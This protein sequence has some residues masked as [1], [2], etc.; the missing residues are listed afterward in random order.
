MPRVMSPAKTEAELQKIREH[1]DE[2]NASIGRAIAADFKWDQATAE[3]VQNFPQE[4]KE[5]LRD[6]SE[7]AQAI[8]KQ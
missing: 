8:S 1:Y 3:D 4:V 5:R 6:C 7:T 2:Y